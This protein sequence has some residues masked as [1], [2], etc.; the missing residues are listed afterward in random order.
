MRGFTSGL[1]CSAIS[2]ALL[3]QGSEAAI[4]PA[5]FFIAY[6]SAGSNHVMI[7]SGVPSEI[8][9]LLQAVALFFITAQVFPAL[10]SA[11]KRT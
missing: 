1:G 8:I 9:S 11:R 6:L 2:V 4:V 10:R 7:G 5:A 3:A